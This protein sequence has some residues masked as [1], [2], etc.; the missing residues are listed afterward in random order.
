MI[1]AVE[2]LCRDRVIT[3][4]ASMLND[5]PHRQ[6]GDDSGVL[7]QPVVDARRFAFQARLLALDASRQASHRHPEV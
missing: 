2:Q 1:A 3:T 5:R 7:H 6:T 4:A